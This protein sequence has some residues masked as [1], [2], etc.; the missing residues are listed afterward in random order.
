M[1]PDEPFTPCL[2]LPVPA[3]LSGVAAQ[4]EEQGK[5]FSNEPGKRLKTSGKTVD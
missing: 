5:S 1:I 3:T 2:F 4:A